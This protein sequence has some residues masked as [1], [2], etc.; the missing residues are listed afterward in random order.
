MI[1]K[2]KKAM[3]DKELENQATADDNLTQ[4]DEVTAQNNEPAIEAPESIS[5]VDQLRIEL[6]NSKDQYLRLVAEFDNFRKRNAKERVELIQTAGKDLIQSLL[7]VMDDSDRAFKTL[8]TATDINAVKEGMNLVLSKLTNILNQKGLK[9]MESPIGKEFDAELHEAITEIPAPS[10][11][12][13]GKVVDVMEKGYYL[14]DKL[15]RYA[16]VI[17]GK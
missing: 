15:I 14:N 12:M 11:D 9:E 1:F 2:K 17:V 4:Q 8:E 13:Q 5:E 16:K 6:S 10:E 3:N 7:A